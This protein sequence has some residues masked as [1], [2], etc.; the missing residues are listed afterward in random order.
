[1]ARTGQHYDKRDVIVEQQLAERRDRQARE[2][3]TAAT[4]SLNGAQTF[5]T[6]LVEGSNAAHL[7]PVINSNKQFHAATAPSSKIQ[8]TFINN[9]NNYHGGSDAPF[10]ARQMPLIGETSPINHQYPGLLDRFS[11]A[12]LNE[13]ERRLADV[14]VP[15][16]FGN[17]C[18]SPTTP[19]VRRRALNEILDQQAVATRTPAPA[20]PPAARISVPTR[21][22]AMPT[23]AFQILAHQ[24]TTIEPSVE[25]RKN[26]DFASR[27]RNNSLEAIEEWLQPRLQDFNARTLYSPR[28]AMVTSPQQ[29]ADRSVNTELLASRYTLAAKSTTQQQPSP[30]ASGDSPKDSSNKR[31][32]FKSA[33]SDS[34]QSFHSATSAASTLDPATEVNTDDPQPAAKKTKTEYQLAP[35]IANR[36]FTLLGMEPIM[37]LEKESYQAGPTAM[38]QNNTLPSAPSSS[39]S[40]DPNELAI[41]AIIRN[42]NAETRRLE[43]ILDANNAETSNSRNATSLPTP[44]A[45]GGGLD[46]TYIGFVLPSADQ[47]FSCA[48]VE[49]EAS[50]ILLTSASH[51]R[52]IGNT[53]INLV[54]YASLDPVLFEDWD[55]TVE[56][57]ARTQRSIE[58]PRTSSAGNER[59]G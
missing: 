17:V 59:S 5:G 11:T 22:Q 14:Y 44:N 4:A 18:D 21:K 51:H 29:E 48:N 12:P 8:Y 13:A 39:E 43:A 37:D 2:T 15:Q 52:N 47:I 50:D 41:D 53:E 9:G 35:P 32:R 19:M 45:F 46:G 54:Q 1:M 36:S 55:R 3:A 7:A 20:V 25:S 27:T 57:Q 26:A 40:V 16:R 38:L 24:S 28:E 33:A 23:A 30:T 42:E 49:L 58:A 10:I 34:S 31:G 6:T 56:A